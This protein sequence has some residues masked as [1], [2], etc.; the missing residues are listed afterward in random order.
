MAL[1]RLPPELLDMIIANALPEGF[2]SI[3]LTSKR[4][5]AL[6]KPL[7]RYHNKLCS[8][9]RNFTYYVKSADPVVKDGSAFDLIARIAVEPVVAKYIQDANFKM[10]GFFTYRKPR[11][12][13]VDAHCEGVARLLA[14][15][16]YLEQAGLDWKEYYAA[17]EEEIATVR[18][19]QHAAAFLLTLLPNVKVLTLPQLWKPLNATDKLVEAIIC[20]VKRP[21][22]PYG[23]SSLSQVTRFEPSVSVLP[24]VRYNLDWA[25]PFLSLPHM[26]SFRGYSCVAIDDGHKSVSSK[27]PY[28]GFG[29]NLQFVDFASCCLDEVDI[30]AFLEHTSQL[31]TLK[32]SHSTKEDGQLQNWD[33]C[34]FITAIER[35]VGSHL[36]QLSVSIRHL[37]GSITPGNVSVRSFPCLQR[38]KLLLEIA[39]CNANATA[40][41]PTTPCKTPV[42]GL[43]DGH[44]ESYESYIDGLVPKSVSQLSLTSSGKGRHEKALAAM[45]RD[46][47]ARK[48]SQF[49]HLK[50]IDL[51]CPDNAD[52]AY[53]NQCSRLLVMAESEGVGLEL[54]PW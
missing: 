13:L 17:I 34:K 54:K 21:N 26:Q 40:Y 20:T 14:D 11:E 5:Y 42:S 51:T 35:K 28:Y 45:F 2:E 52:I 3:A 47:P 30:A 36:V 37:G 9:F 22:L 46:F 32:Y 7:I 44:L 12:L 31:R 25:I 29:E 41:L 39:M 49:P 18:Y 43:I 23:G 53:K 33:I 6:C 27:N 50:E 24:K 16:P 38:L 10:D 19:S 8:Q 1:M 15:S 48:S 4:A